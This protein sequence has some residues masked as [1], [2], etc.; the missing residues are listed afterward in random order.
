MNAKMETAADLIRIIN[1]QDLNDIRALF[2]GNKIDLDTF[3]KTIRTFVPKNYI[4][5]IALID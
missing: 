3:S 5:T 1:P 2:S 4:E